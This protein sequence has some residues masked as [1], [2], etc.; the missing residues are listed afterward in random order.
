MLR[1]SSA[2]RAARRRR[3]LP[4]SGVVTESPRGRRALSTSRP[5]RRVARR[6]RRGTARVSSRLSP[7]PRRRA[8]RS[9]GPRS[10]PRASA[11]G[12]R[13]RSEP[14]TRRSWMSQ[15]GTRPRRIR[16]GR[17]RR[18]ASSP[19]HL[20]RVV[21][22]GTRLLRRSGPSRLLPRARARRRRP[23]ARR[24]LWK[25]RGP[26]PRRCAAGPPCLRVAPGGRAAKSWSPWTQA[27]VKRRFASG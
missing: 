16:R 5:P 2:A 7:R 1:A 22:G 15:S 19:R 18:P 14:R 10:T 21:R 25:R 17:P 23:A 20:A 4:L 9:R 27:Q 8:R 26:P 24:L 3:R 11:R 12:G 6:T 13:T